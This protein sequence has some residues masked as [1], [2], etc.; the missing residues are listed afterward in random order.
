MNQGVVQVA[1]NHGDETVGRF[2]QLFYRLAAVVSFAND[3]PALLSAVK[4]A[5]LPGGG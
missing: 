2:E 1:R 4:T 5:L 3:G